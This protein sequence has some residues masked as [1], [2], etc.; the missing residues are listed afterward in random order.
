MQAT[1]SGNTRKVGLEHMHVRFASAQHVVLWSAMLC[2][3][4]PAIWIGF[5]VIAGMAD[6]VKPNMHTPSC[7]Q[8]K[9]SLIQV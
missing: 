6:V 3:E 5:D 1:L 7:P 9:P 4:V 8:G 2:Y